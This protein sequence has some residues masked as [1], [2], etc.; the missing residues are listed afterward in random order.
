MARVIVLLIV[1]DAILILLGACLR[2]LVVL[3]HLLLMLHLHLE[4]VLVGFFA[5]DYHGVRGRDRG[6]R[7]VVRP[8]IVPLLLLLL[9]ADPLLHVKIV[10]W[11]IALWLLH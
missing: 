5:W 3:L 11:S 4:I 1:D 2:I 8:V 6:H 7:L 9:E 10:H